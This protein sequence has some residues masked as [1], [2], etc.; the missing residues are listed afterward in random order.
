MQQAGQKTFK[1]VWTV[2][3]T[4]ATRRKWWSRWICPILDFVHGTLSLTFQGLGYDIHSQAIGAWRTVEIRAWRRV[5][6]IWGKG[7]M[8]WTM[9]VREQCFE[10]DSE[11]VA[12]QLSR[13][14]GED[15]PEKR[16][17]TAEKGRWRR[18]YL[19]TR[20]QI[21]ILK[22][23]LQASHTAKIMCL[24]LEWAMNICDYLPTDMTRY[25]SHWMSNKTFDII[26]IPQ[27]FPVFSSNVSPHFATESCLYWKSVL[28]QINLVQSRHVATSR[29]S[30]T[31]SFPAVTCRFTYCAPIL[32]KVPVSQ[33]FLYS[34]QTQ[35]SP[36]SHPVS[37]IVL[38]SRVLLLGMGPKFL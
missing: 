26:T 22:L 28:V 34:S 7:H 32:T 14:E 30:C 37:A 5:L 12:Y 19:R 13:M 23:K 33:E 31:I 8:I 3:I 25:F 15:D 17:T 2:H 38:R 16:I 36:R 4:L 1:V 10:V 18:Q 6:G 9:R 29:L 24:L 20:F 11:L 21:Q 27:R 35:A